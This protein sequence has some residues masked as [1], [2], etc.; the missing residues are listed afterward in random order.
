MSLRGRRPAETY[1]GIPCKHGHSGERYKANNVHTVCARKAR[2]N[3]D[4]S[5]ERNAQK[6]VHPGDF[7]HRVMVFGNPARVTI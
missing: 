3:R 4:R 1:L 6:S 2:A 7:T 5:G